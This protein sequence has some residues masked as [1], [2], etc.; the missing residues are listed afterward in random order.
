MGNPGAE[1]RKEFELP[2]ADDKKKRLRKPAAH[3]T[4]ESKALQQVFNGRLQKL[5]AARKEARIALISALAGKATASALNKEQKSG[6]SPCDPLV[7]DNNFPWK[8]NTQRDGN[9][10]AAAKSGAKAGN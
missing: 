10:A 7:A 5:K 9:C 8:A 3:L 4:K 2:I 6:D 1:L